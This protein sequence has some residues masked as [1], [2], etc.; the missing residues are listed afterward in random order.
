MNVCLI[1]PASPFLINQDVMGHL[2]LWYLGSA[3]REA[4]HQVLYCDLGLGDEIP[5]ADVY[6]VTGMS[7]QA[8]QVLELPS[9]LRQVSSKALLVGGGPYLSLRPQDGIEAGYDLIIQGEGE[10]VFVHILASEGS[11]QYPII[12]APR[13]YDLDALAFPDRSQAGRYHYAVDGVGATTMITSRGCPY[14]CAF[15]CTSI[16]GG[17]YRERSPQNVYMEMAAL[18]KQGWGAVM[19]YDDTLALNQE[20]LAQLC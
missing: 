6:G 10:R 3:L 11:E 5:L 2:G 19:F 9:R 20:R 1:A 18:R 17:R 14:R 8:S 12:H 7:P 4:G 16:W 15:C 13:N